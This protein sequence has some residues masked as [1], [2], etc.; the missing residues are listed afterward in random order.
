M[1]KSLD[2]GWL[3]S[4]DF[5]KVFHNW[6]RNVKEYKDVFLGY[7]SNARD[8]ADKIS[9]FLTT[10]VGVSVF[11][12]HEPVAGEAIWELVARAEQYTRCGIFLFMGDDTIISEDKHRVA[13]RDNVVY[14]AGYFAGAKGKA[15]S[16]II[17]ER[18]TKLPSDLDGIIHLP[19]DRKELGPL[20]VS[21]RRQI[22]QMLRLTEPVTVY[23]PD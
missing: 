10:E 5:Q 22:T 7:S 6:V 16:I 13:P 23:R 9:E 3:D 17:H 14:E 20:E 4:P 8:V 1:P 21:L 12:W 11:D 19:L 15:C 2:I 18:D